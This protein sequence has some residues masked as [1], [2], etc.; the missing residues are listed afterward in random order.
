[1]KKIIAVIAV[2]GVMLLGGCD[3][4][5]K[6]KEPQTINL[7][8]Y[9]DYTIEGYSTKAELTYTIRYDDIIDDFE[10]EDVAASRLEKK[11]TGTWSKMTYLA[12]GDEITFEW[13]V[14]AD[15]IEEK[16]NVEFEAKDLTVEV[17]DLDEMPEFDPFEYIDV[18]FSGMTGDGTLTIDTLD[19]IPL[20]DIRYT[21]DG[22]SYY[23]SNGD[24]VTIVASTYSGADL[25][26]YCEDNDYILVNDTSTYTVEGLDDYVSDIGE[27]TDDML[28]ELQGQA[29]DSITAFYDLDEGESIAAVNYVG[30][31]LLDNKSETSYYQN[32]VYLIYEVTITTPAGDMVLY[33]YVRFENVIL[34]A[35]G[36]NE[37]YDILDTDMPTSWDSEVGIGEYSWGSYEYEHAGY[38]DVTA[39][40]NGEIRPELEEYNITDTIPDAYLNTAPAEE[41][42]E[43]T[44]APAEEPVEETEAPAEEVEE[45][46]E[47]G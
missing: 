40:Y 10:L 11:V 41:S 32:F 42:A 4:A 20:D 18:S 25:A 14:D 31:Y 12:N 7:N 6:A 28:A 19:G 5:A 22:S 39:L 9:I 33:T 27:L 17:K 36:T 37:I 47:E 38:T 8:D 26:D 43:E 21:V 23:L 15:S 16:Y 35:D 44:E 30:L 34:L 3:K 46:V 2:A 1:M 24:E 13:T 45:T 29:S